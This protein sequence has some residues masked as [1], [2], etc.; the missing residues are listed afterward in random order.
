MDCLWDNHVSV[1]SMSGCLLCGTFVCVGVIVG[2]YYI[3]ENDNDDDDDSNNDRGYQHPSSSINHYSIV[4]DENNHL[5]GEECR[6]QKKNSKNAMKET[7]KPNDSNN[8][9]SIKSC[10][11]NSNLTSQ[12]QELASSYSTLSPRVGNVLPNVPKIDFATFDAELEVYKS[13]IPMESHLTQNNSYKGQLNNNNNTSPTTNSNVNNGYNIFNAQRYQKAIE[14]TKGLSI[15]EKNDNVSRT[16]ITSCLK[17]YQYAISTQQDPE[18]KKNLIL[19]YE[20]AKHLYD[21]DNDD[22]SVK[23]E[24]YSKAARNEHT[25]VYTWEEQIHL[26]QKAIVYTNDIAKKKVLMEEYKAFCRYMALKSD[27]GAATNHD[28][29]KAS[30]NAI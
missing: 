19:Q 7:S 16:F 27:I 23:A 6:P 25:N 18:E 13:F 26:Y 29:L 17:Q 21:I 12:Q 10:T 9:Y 2:N 30:N 5:P 28:A 4:D 20:K 15:D 8:L 24:I 14:Y 22:D 1:D 11:S 3:D